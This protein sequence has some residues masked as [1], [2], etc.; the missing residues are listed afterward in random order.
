[1]TLS[2]LVYV[3]TASPEL[4]EIDLDAILQTARTRNAAAGL[5]GLLVFNGFNFM[6]LLEGPTAPLEAVFAS[7][8]ADQRHSGVVRVHYDAA[9][10][11]RI[12]SDWDM[13]YARTGAGNAGGVF[14]LTTETLRAYLPEKLSPD[15]HMLF[16][17]FNSMS[18]FVPTPATPEGLQPAQ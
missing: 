3:S 18:T 7:I 11:T 13:A 8:C 17:S 15:L 5:T 14:A 9:A 1:M 4:A 12:F 2:R 16:V 10:Q 6:Q